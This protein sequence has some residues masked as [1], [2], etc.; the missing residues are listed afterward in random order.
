MVLG[1]RL[2][3]LFVSCPFIAQYVKVMRKRGPPTVVAAGPPGYDMT[4]KLG[5][6]LT[7]LDSMIGIFSDMIANQGTGLDVSGVMLEVEH[8]ARAS[9]A[10]LGKD[11]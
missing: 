6:H 9:H 5:L 3:K 2:N 4:A 7:L 10:K 11:T 1:F 8:R